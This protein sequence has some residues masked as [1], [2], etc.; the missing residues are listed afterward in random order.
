M[1][2]NRTSAP[3]GYWPKLMRGQITSDRRRAYL[4]PAV[5]RVRDARRRVS[6]P[7]DRSAFRPRRIS[8]PPRDR[9]YELT[10]LSLYRLGL[11]GTYAKYRFVP[12]SA[13][14][15][16]DE[17]RETV[18]AH[19]GTGDLH[20]LVAALWQ[21]HGAPS[22]GVVDAFLDA[23]RALD[24]LEAAPSPLELEAILEHPCAL[25]GAARAAP[26]DLDEAGRRLLEAWLRACAP[27]GRAGRMRDQAEL[28]VCFVLRRARQY[29]YAASAVAPNAQRR[30]RETG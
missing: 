3:T 13:I 7:L 29:V 10:R 14:G 30:T 2:P 22:R 6:G 11:A 4:G 26:R 19:P 9:S 12:R 5:A 1:S 21:R 18:R 25:A 8:L 23:A 28:A 16:Y 17:L 20:G 27:R 24:R 15:S